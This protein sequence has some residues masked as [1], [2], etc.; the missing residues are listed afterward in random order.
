MQTTRPYVGENTELPP[1]QRCD[2]GHHPVR[3]EGGSLYLGYAATW[4]EKTQIETPSPST[5]PA[6]LVP[7]ATGHYASTTIENAMLS[8]ISCEGVGWRVVHAER[9]GIG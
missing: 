8:S 2:C 7:S 5:K 4:G 1:D 6:G 9:R 3:L